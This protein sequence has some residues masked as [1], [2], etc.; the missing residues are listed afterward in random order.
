MGKTIFIIKKT[1]IDKVLKDILVLRNDLQKIDHKIPPDVVG[2]YGELL[3][4]NQ[5]RTVFGK[6]GY[7][8]SLGSGQSKADILLWKGNEKLNDKNLSPV[9][10]A[11]LRAQLEEAKRVQRDRFGEKPSIDN[12]S[13][14]LLKR[15]M[16][17]APADPNAPKSY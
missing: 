3:A 9:E 6:K 12:S 8:V 10:A 16:S 11:G 7:S 5:L 14:A 17:N 2:F 4:W 1:A 15:I 13:D